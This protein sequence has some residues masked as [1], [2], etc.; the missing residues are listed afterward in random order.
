MFPK[1]GSDVPEIRFKGFSDNW[2]RYKL[3]EVVTE[4]VAGGDIDNNLIR[5][6]GRFPVIAN[7]ITK[8][9]IVGYYDTKYRVEAPAVTVTGRGYVGHAK[10]RNV[11]FTPVVRLLSL[12]SNHDVF[13]LEN[14]INTLKIV[15]ESTGV[16][17]L[18]IPQLSKYEI[19]LPKTLVEEQKI[20]SYFRNIDTIITLHERKL[21]KLK[22]IKKT[23]I[24]KMFV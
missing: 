24:E 11:N 19:S 20:G 1:K 15:V 5:E 23:C 22:N 16:P 21:E 8:D 7:A 18:T 10:V 12:K 2:E 17:Q 3:E 4:I 9:G 13:F 14:A 6:K